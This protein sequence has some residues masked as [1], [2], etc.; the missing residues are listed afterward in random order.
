MITKNNCPIEIQGIS[1]EETLKKSFKY[2]L[3]EG[4]Y[5]E[6]KTL[7]ILSIIVIKKD[8]GYVSKCKYVNKT[9]LST[10]KILSMEEIIS[11]IEKNTLLLK[12]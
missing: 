2:L 5:I 3:I 8:M 4:D 9:Y 10:K 12:I 1:L 6:I 7:N 11:E